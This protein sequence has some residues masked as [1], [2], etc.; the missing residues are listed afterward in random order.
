MAWLLKIG[1]TLVAVLRAIPSLITISRLVIEQI[2]KISESIEARK[3]LKA[4]KGEIQEVQDSDIKDTSNIEHI[5]N[6]DST[7]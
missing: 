3:K 1:S 2:K 6:D 4:M 7:K 5:L